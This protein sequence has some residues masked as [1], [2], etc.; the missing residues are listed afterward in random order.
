MMVGTKENGMPL[1]SITTATYNCESTL[2]RTIE[3]VL[4]QSYPAIEYT[5]MDGLSTD[6]TLELA[7]SYKADFLS[8]GFSYKVISQADSGMYDA[9][10][11]AM[12]M[13]TGEILGNV[14]GDDYFEPDAVDRVVEKYLCT[15]FD[16]VYGD[17]RV[18]T[19]RGALIKKASRMRLWPTTRKW[20]HP[21]MFLANRALLL[22]YRLDNMYADF[23]LFLRAYNQGMSIETVSGVVS[24]FVFGGMS[25]KKSVDEVRSR[26]ALRNQIYRD[27][28]CP[29]MTYIEGAAIEILKYLKA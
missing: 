16:V 2:P 1:V 10:N 17:L 18:H 12:D 28:G 8:R 15:G 7:E 5:I 20:N 13:S 11:H 9:I 6:R 24:N 4:D 25:T 21:T 22:R 26:I 14:N 23:D 3:S 27:N 29:P 19:A